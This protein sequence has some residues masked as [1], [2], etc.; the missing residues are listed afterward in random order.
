MP[1]EEKFEDAPSGWVNFNKVGDYVK[2]TLLDIKTP[3][4]PDQWGK[5]RRVFTLKVWEGEYHPQNEDKT[6]GAKVTLQPGEIVRFTSKDA[7]DAQ[8][9][10]TKLDQKII[11]RF[12]ESKPTKKGNNAKIIKVQNGPMDAAAVAERNDFKSS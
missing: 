9:T 7:I 5:I 6:L 4:E 2:A 8:M 10:Q 3:T 12:T 1:E 11:L